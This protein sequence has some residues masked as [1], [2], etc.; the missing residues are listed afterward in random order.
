[1]K[2]AKELKD[3]RSIS[4]LNSAYK[5]K[6]KVLALR[7]K[8]EMEGLVMQSQGAFVLGRQILDGVLVANE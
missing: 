1:M 4:L 6:A 8:L 3:F 7:I 2:A 5:I